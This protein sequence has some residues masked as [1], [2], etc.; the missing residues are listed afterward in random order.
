MELVKIIIVLVNLL[1][2]K[3]KLIKRKAYGA[4]THIGLMIGPF[5]TQLIIKELI[6]HLQEGM[7]R[8]LRN[9]SIWYLLDQLILPLDQRKAFLFKEGDIDHFLL[10][11]A[12]CAVQE[13]FSEMFLEKNNEDLKKKSKEVKVSKAKQLM[14]KVG[15]SVN[16][17]GQILYSTVALIVGQVEGSRDLKMVVT[18]AGD[19]LNGLIAG[20]IANR[21]VHPHLIFFISYLYLSEQKQHLQFEGRKLKQNEGK[22]IEEYKVISAQ[23]IKSNSKK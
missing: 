12:N 4:L 15:Q 5:L 20:I 18:N 7:L 16:L 21:T 3:D 1:K 19:L 9:Y 22:L 23:E 6:F 8:H 10:D 17:E 14:F 11:V 2:H 13:Y